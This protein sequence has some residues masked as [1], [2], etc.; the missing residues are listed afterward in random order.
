M[1]LCPWAV[2]FTFMCSSPIWARYTLG[3]RFLCPRKEVPRMVKMI[4]YKI[5]LSSHIFLQPPVVLNQPAESTCPWRRLS[6]DYHRQ[7]WRELNGWRTEWG[8]VRELGGRCARSIQH[9]K[10]VEGVWIRG[11]YLASGKEHRHRWAQWYSCE[12]VLFFFHFF[13]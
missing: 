2:I 13:V 11:T 8:T 5:S 9:G 3:L 7:Q 12:S 4:T 10:D 6:R 1:F